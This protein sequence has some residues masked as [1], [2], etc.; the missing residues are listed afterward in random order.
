MLLE[1]LSFFTE[2]FKKIKNKYNKRIA[3]KNEVIKLK[4]IV[5]KSILE[6]FQKLLV[7]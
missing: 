3:I 1:S 2:Y 7:I 4:I 6:L 5:V